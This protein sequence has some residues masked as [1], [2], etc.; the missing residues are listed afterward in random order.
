[1]KKVFTRGSLNSD[2]GQSTIE[3]ALTLTVLMAFALFFIQLCLVFGFGNFVHYAT[4]MS[5]RAY[6][7]AGKTATDQEDRARKVIIQTLK[8]SEGSP[9]TDRFPTIAKAKDG[10]N[11][12]GAFIGPGSNYDPSKRNSFWM[13]GVRYRFASRL[14]VLPL[15][16]KVNG[17]QTKQLLQLTS[18]S[19]L[20][21]EPTFEE[22]MDKMQKDW[23]L[24]NGC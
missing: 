6:M 13:Q 16:G 22:C 20:G 1:M 24:D 15:S 7:A 17:T 9:N 10:D 4:F 2:Q 8:K 14:F 12:A 5:A 18:E 3:F 21:R 19:W 11:P 23:V